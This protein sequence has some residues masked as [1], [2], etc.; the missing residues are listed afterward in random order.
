MPFDFDAA[1]ARA[2]GVALDATTT[3]VVA[4]PAAPKVR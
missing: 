4:R 3:T 2:V 1:Y